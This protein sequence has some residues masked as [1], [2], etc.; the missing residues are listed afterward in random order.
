MLKVAWLVRLSQEADRDVALRAW[1]EDHAKLIRDVPGVERYPHNQAIALAEGPG[2]WTQAPA[3]D[4]VVCTWWT[5][6]AA[7]EAALGSSAWREVLEHG[8]EIFDPD[9]ALANMAVVVQ[10]RVMRIG[11]G[12]PWSG[13]DVPAPM[14]KHI[15]VLYF[16]PGMERGD[17]SAHWTDVHGALALEIPEIRYYVQD[18]GIRALRLDGVD[19]NGRF[20][21]DGFSEAWF[22]D[23]ET[24]ER[25]HESAAWY[26]L[27]DDSPNLFDMEAIEA[28]VNCVVEERVIKG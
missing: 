3:I 28:G 6:Q 21:F 13:A 24:F 11:P 1:N 23:R 25:S 9:F 5:D 26:R 16:R 7:L 10:E 20:A 27:R 2:A 22:T 12:T 18:H 4:G 17:A 8:R 14:C 19:G 15:G